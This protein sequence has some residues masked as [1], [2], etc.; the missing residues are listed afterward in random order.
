MRILI[1]PTGKPAAFQK[2][3]AKHLQKLHGLQL[4]TGLWKHQEPIPDAL[5]PAAG[6][7]ALP[8]ERLHRSSY[9]PATTVAELCHSDP[10][11][12]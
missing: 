6:F 11:Q 12:W 4:C 5:I 10:L 8:L 1:L 2:A 9:A 3:E 7:F